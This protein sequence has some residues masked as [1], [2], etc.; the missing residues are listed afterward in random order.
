MVSKLELLKLYI[1]YLPILSPIYSLYLLYDFSLYLQ[2]I[3]IF[4]NYFC[5]KQQIC[6]TLSYNMS[7]HS[8]NYRD[9]Y[10]DEQD[11]Y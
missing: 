11:Q 8:Q 1:A 7:P 4:Y 6:N 3:Y 9:A 10:I 2:N 5:Q